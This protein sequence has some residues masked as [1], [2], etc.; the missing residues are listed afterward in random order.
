MDRNTVHKFCDM[1]DEVNSI[2]DENI[3]IAEKTRNQLQN[4]GSQIDNIGDRLINIEYITSKGKEIINRMSSFFHRF[5]TKQ[6]NVTANVTEEPIIME[7]INPSQLFV[8]NDTTLNKLNRLKKIGIKI[9]EEIDE[10]NIK[11]D[12]MD[13]EMDKNKSYLKKNVEKINKIL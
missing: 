8:K 2:L 3:E 5:R 10:Q 9:G 11:F 12:K 7:E 13:I 6:L 1:E 4:Q